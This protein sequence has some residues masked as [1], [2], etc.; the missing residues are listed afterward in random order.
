VNT[1][2]AVEIKEL[3]ATQNN[4]VSFKNLLKQQLDS[5]KARFDP[6]QSVMQLLLDKAQFIDLLL[7]TAWTHFLADHTNK[8]SLVA[9]GGYGRQ[10]LFPYSD[11]DILILLDGI[12]TPKHQE[13]L[14]DFCRF[15][16]D[17]GLKPGLS[18]RT[19]A[20]C[21]EAL[22]DDQTIMTSLLEMRLIHG[23]PE[24]FNQIQQIINSDKVWPPEQFFAAKMHEQQLR[25]F[26]YHDTAYNLEPNVKE[27]PGGLRDLQVIAWV[28]K[29]YYHSASLEELIAYHFILA[30]EYHELIA[31]R[32]I[33]WRTRYALHL[34][35]N[36]NEDRLLFDCQHDLAVQFGFT[37]GDYNQITEQFM[38]FYFKTVVGLERLNEMLLQLFKERLTTSQ[39]IEP[40]EINDCF[41]AISGY[42]E[43]KN[44][45][46]FQQQPLLLL[47]LFLVLQKNPHL[48][49]IRA[50]TIRLIRNNLDLIDDTFRYDKAAN[51]LFMEILRQ[52]VGVTHLLRRMNRYGILAAYLPSFANIVARMQYDLF[53]VYTVDEHTLFVIGN[54]RRFSLTKYQYELPFCYDVFALISKP[55]VL[56]IAALFHDIAKGMGG[57]HSTLGEEMAREFC[58]QHELSSHDTK[59]ITWLVRNHLLM[60]MTAQRKDISDPEVIYEFASQ[61]G[62][63]EYLNHIYLLTVADIRAT[64]PTLWNSWKDALLQELYNLTLRAL[65]H[66]LQNPITVEQRLMENKKEANDELLKQ[67]L[68]QAL[69]EASWQHTSDDY[70][71]RYT[72][73]EIVWHTLAIASCSERDLPLVLLRLHTQRG[74]AEVFVYAKNEEMIFS[75]STATLDQLGLTILDARIITTA[76]QYV[77][78]SFQVLEQSGQPINDETRKEH[79][80]SSLRA[81]L[82]KKT[83]KVQ[84]NIHRQSRQAKHFPIATTVFFPD[85]SVS[86]FTVVE[87]VTTDRSGLLSD[88][89]QIFIALNIQL[90]DAKITTIGSRV[91]DIFYITD[92]SGNLLTDMQKQQLQKMLLETGAL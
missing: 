67:G 60:S 48:K 27:G 88:I 22:K 75:I 87:L 30:S 38:Q 3:F 19:V 66:G 28:F 78:N 54:L 16:W 72:T 9:V 63:S 51:R 7:T 68:C 18:V 77:L 20:E 34:L 2:S 49:G 45:Q 15:I 71:L 84:K 44:E 41:V 62:N 6:H 4:I 10:E 11:I 36:R 46:I 76:D 52:P 33:L 86:R 47:E 79:I 37:E 21:V 64:S 81:N 55:E 13:A 8:L 35:T 69:I 80:C 56:Y 43:A 82:L 26:K 50:T 57:D 70:F 17:I 40:V 83:I 90:H 61:V 23:N 85:D 59:L 92:K 24:L 1:T 31:A 14:S 53:H 89:G 65:R 29:R 91:E 39:K 74:S 12:Q 58:F 32:D 5:L 73:D 42:L 25:Y